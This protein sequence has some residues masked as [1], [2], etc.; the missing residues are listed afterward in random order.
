MTKS[1]KMKK[2]HARKILAPYRDPDKQLGSAW[3]SKIHEPSGLSYQELRY[4]VGQA[5]VVFGNTYEMVMEMFGVSKG[6][7]SK[8]ANVF[9]ASEFLK[10]IDRSMKKSDLF[11]SL[12]NRPD[13]IHLQIP[14]DIRK[15]IVRYRNDTKAGSR[16]IRVWLME[17]HGA[18]VSCTGIDNVMRS[19]GQIKP[20]KHRNRGYHGRFEREHS[21]SMVQIDYKTWPSGVK[22]IWV[23]DD[24][25]RAI[26]GYAV[27]DSQSTD[28]VLKLLEDTFSFWG[29][30]PEQILSDHGA[31]FYSVAGG[32]GASRLDKWCEENGIEHIMGR[33]RHPQTQGKIER[34]HGTATAEIGRF[35]SMDSVEEARETVAGWVDYYNNR[36]PH[37]ALDDGYP[38]NA[39]FEKLPYDRFERFLEGREPIV[40]PS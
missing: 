11:R 21:L 16:K 8:W 35:G 27:S 26:L 17:D 31:E 34:S 14:E 32:A 9:R 24:A 29:C 5:V 6:F 40:I 18:Y 23:L 19:A 33:V 25:S 38:M 15:A 2:E 7:I 4:R 22:T 3:D 12:S 10:S 30:Y 37:M 1:P 28:E 20:G 13:R 36:R 39:F